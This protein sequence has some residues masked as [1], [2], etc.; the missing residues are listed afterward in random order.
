MEEKL[1][2]S[3]WLGMAAGDRSSRRSTQMQSATKRLEKSIKTSRAPS[4]TLSKNVETSLR[5]VCV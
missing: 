5:Q 2:E 1:I 3:V 4:S